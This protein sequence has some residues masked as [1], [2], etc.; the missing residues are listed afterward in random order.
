MRTQIYSDSDRRKMLRE[1]AYIAERA[2]HELNC[3]SRPDRGNRWFLGE[4]SMR[5]WVTLFGAAGVDEWVAEGCEGSGGA[6]DWVGRLSGWSLLRCSPT[7][8]WE[9]VLA[10]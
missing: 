9:P 6:G 7:D 3:S 4:G 10:L 5:W 2:R 1:R 8:G